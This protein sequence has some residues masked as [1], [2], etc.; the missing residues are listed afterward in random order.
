MRKSA[1]TKC[2]LRWRTR[3]SF[4]EHMLDYN[5]KAERMGWLPSRAPA[6]PQPAA[7]YQGCGSGRHGSEGVRGSAAEER[8]SAVCREAPDAPENFPRNLFIWRSNL[9][10]SSGK[11]HEY[12]L[13]Y[14]LGTRNGVMNEDLGKAG[15]LQAP[16]SRVG[17]TKAPTG[18]LDLVT[19]LD[20]RMS[21][22]CLYSD[23]VLPTASWYEKD[24]LNTSDMHPFIHPL[25]T[26][27]DPV[28]EARSDWDIY[29]GIAKKFSEVAA[30][31]TGCG[32]RHCHRA[33]AARHA[34]GA[35]P[36]L[37]RKGLEKRRVRSDSWRYRSQHVV[38]ERDYP[39]TY[40]KFTSLG[41]LM[42]KLGNGGKG[43]G[44][45]TDD[46][47]ELLRRS[48]SSQHGRRDQPGPAHH[49][50]RDRCLRNRAGAGAGDQRQR[51]GEGLGCARHKDRA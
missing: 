46:E 28:W 38:V 23:I 41:P 44:W 25:S 50:V 14:L 13:K 22:T 43:I 33:H 31:R 39:N 26:A 29:K 49:R 8:R 36:A 45:N 34:R 35:G 2:F 51:G 21:S 32:E 15:E 20:F 17:A 11:G 4:P 5:I 42:D 18:K 1:F 47:I 7:D 40:K 6:E 30:G 3:T 48:E 24:D 9:L 10:G 37:R 27:V 16:G 19:T 12:M